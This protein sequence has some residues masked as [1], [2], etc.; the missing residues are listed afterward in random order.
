MNLKRRELLQVVA[1]VAVAWVAVLFFLTRWQRE[2]IPTSDVREPELIHYPGTEGIEEQTSENLG[3]RKYWFTL[4]EDYPSKSVYYFY[5]N[6]LEPEGWRPLHQ[7]EPRWVRQT[8]K[9]DMR[10]LFQAVW[11][12]PD[13][14]FQIELEM[15]S[16]LHPIEQGKMTVGSEREPGIQVFVTLRRS[17]HPSII[18]EP[19]HQSKPTL[20]I[21]TPQ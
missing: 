15:M 11:V 14:L 8:W 20:D 21:D 10:D 19:R 4:N 2:T 12:S 3:F 7:A 18:L 1:L 13:S 5:A 16:V 9:K 17:L 6:Q